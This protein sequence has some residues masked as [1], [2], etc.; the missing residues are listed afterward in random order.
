M[1]YWEK[2]SE[3]KVEDVMKK[4][5]CCPNDFD[6]DEH[7]AVGGHVIRLL[8]QSNGELRKVLGARYITPIC[9][10]CNVSN[11][12]RPFKV[13]QKFLIQAPGK[14]DEK[15]NLPHVISPS[16]RAVY[17]LMIRMHLIKPDVI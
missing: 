8:L 12:M 14:P 6:E 15:Q 16:L 11:K 5:P 9:N 10:E 7:K 13:D 17:N 2:K 1:D 3:Y 4:C